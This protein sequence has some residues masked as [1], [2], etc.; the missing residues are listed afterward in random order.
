MSTRQVGPG[1][2]VEAL[3]SIA[4]FQSLALPDLEFVASLLPMFGG[5]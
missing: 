1:P 2:K 4:A 5:R 3:R